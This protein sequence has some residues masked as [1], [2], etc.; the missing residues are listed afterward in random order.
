M[1]ASCG[2]LFLLGQLFEGWDFPAFSLCLFCLP[3]LLSDFLTKR[4]PFRLP[5]FPSRFLVPRGGG[6]VRFGPLFRVSLSLVCISVAAGLWP[7]QIL[8]CE[9]VS[10]SLGILKVFLCFLNKA[11]F[12]PRFGLS[13]EFCFSLLPLPLPLEVLFFCSFRTGKKND[14]LFKSSSKMPPFFPFV[15][16]NFGR[17]VSLSCFLLRIRKAVLRGCLFRKCSF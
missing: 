10:D 15:R 11:P 1:L 12:S 4:I 13:D 9:G 14:L 2:R 6:S 3:C 5:A 17:K 7:L 16:K 8:V